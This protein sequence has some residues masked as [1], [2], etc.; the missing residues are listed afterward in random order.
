MKIEVSIGELV[1][2]VSILSIKLDKIKDVNKLKNIR[3]EFRLLFESMKSVGITEH[4]KEFC[5]LRAINLKLWDIEDKIRLK[6]WKR[7][8]DQEFIQ[9]ARSIYYEND[10]RSELKKKINVKMGSSIIE[11]KEYHRYNGNAVE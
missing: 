5:Q 6:E 3:H 10:K 7:E 2:K 1:D 9:L 11:E 4:T 8:F